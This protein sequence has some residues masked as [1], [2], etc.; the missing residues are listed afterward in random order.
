MIMT[1]KLAEKPFRAIKEGRKTIEMRLYDEKRK[2]LSAGDIIE[3][4][5]LDNKEEVVQTKVLA[6]HIYSS[7]AEL[8]T[9]FSKKEMGYGDDEVADPKDMEKYF[10]LEKQQKYGAVVGIEI[11]LLK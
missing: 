1:M 4:I 11:E 5:N 2:H 6:I 8:Y 7:F 9:N 10:P 3:F